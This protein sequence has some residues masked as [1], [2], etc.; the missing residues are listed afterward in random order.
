VRDARLL[1]DIKYRS[2]FELSM[3]GM[4]LLDPD[5]YAIVDTNAAFCKLSGR[6]K[7]ELLAM[8]LHDLLAP[9]EWDR[10][11]Q[12][13]GL[14][15]NGGQGTLS[16]LAF[17]HMDGTELSLDVS[18]TF[19]STIAENIVFLAFKDVTEKRELEE[20]LAKMAQTDTLTGLANRRTFDLRLAW[21][22]ARA[23]GEQFAVSLLAMDVD[24]FKQCN[25]TYGHPIGDK[26]LKGVGDLIRENI[27]VGGDEGFRYGGDEF[28]VL[29]MGV[30]TS[31][32]KRI[33]DRI[34]AD[35]KQGESYGTG[36]SIGIAELEDGMEVSDLISRA[37]EALY[38]AKALGKNVIQV[39]STKDGRS[40]AS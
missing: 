35:H 36:L 30:H 10:L 24:N 2:L 33:A 23:R 39:A 1:A 18:A 13:L 11:K 15:A 31:T 34:R 9:S 3:N 28:A 22:I 12:S 7:S 40:P 32:A 20:G 8:T 26:V 5:T 6:S 16:D 21:A 25:D 19:I 37:D 4:L 38:R 29:L 17:A 14:F 27:R